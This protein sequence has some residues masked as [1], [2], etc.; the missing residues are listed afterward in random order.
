MIYALSSISHTL[1]FFSTEVHLLGSSFQGLGC[2][3]IKQGC[4]G[5]AITEDRSYGLES[6]SSG[7][8][9]TARLSDG[10][11]GDIATEHC[12]SCL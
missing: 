12:Q 10:D 1:R 5:K 2:D 9:A 4:S 3:R 8:H 11:M 7:V 6:V